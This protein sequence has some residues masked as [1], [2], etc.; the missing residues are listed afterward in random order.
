MA[1]DIEHDLWLIWIRAVELCQAQREK[2]GWGSQIYFENEIPVN[3]ISRDYA[4]FLLK[5]KE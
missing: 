2:A 5:F 1:F 4:C 3:R